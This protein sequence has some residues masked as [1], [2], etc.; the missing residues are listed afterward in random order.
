[1][2][3]ILGFLVYT[4]VVL[5]IPT[6]GGFIVDR[7]KVGQRKSATVH[8]LVALIILGLVFVLAYY[9]WAA[10]TA[11]DA[12]SSPKLEYLTKQ[13][14]DE[15]LNLRRQHHLPVGGDQE[16]LQV[17][18]LKFD[19]ADYAQNK[20]DFERAVQLY[21]DI[22]R[23]SDENGAFAT[24]PSVC[25][26]NNMALDVFRKDGDRGFRASSLLLGAL[27]LGPMPQHHI[28]LI[29]HNIDELDRYINQ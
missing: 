13:N 11:R 28:D 25:V 15:E 12:R 8:S 5:A 23:G 9:G 2:K 6:Y 14:L 3:A 26:E 22:E 16:P 20:N 29:K 10:Q 1:M 7:F 19:E 27:K 24:F 4:A 18:K 17:M 21:T